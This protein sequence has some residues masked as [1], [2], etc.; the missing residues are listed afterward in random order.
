MAIALV[1]HGAEGRMG[2]RLRALA[3]RDERFETVVAIGRASAAETVS[4]ADVVVDFSTD[5]G[6]AGAARLAQRIGA[7]LLV[8]TTG[9][10][11]GTLDVLGEF[12]RS[13]PLLIAPNTS[14]GVAVLRHLAAVA[15]RLLDGFDVDLIEQHHRGKLDAPSGTARALTLAVEDAGG[16]VPSDR[17]HC[18]RAGGIFGQHILQFSGAGEVLRLEHTALGRDVFAA[19]AL[20]AAAWLVGRP[21]GRYAIEHVLGLPT[22]GA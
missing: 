15:T 8:G 16:A 11:A 18:V 19:G 3:E 20:D 17:V 22:E 7:S 5:E 12:A 13:G 10:S 6:A 21:P 1:V 4:H 2:T 9:L 14:R